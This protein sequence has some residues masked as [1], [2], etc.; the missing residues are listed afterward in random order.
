[1]VQLSV[2]DFRAAHKLLL[3]ARRPDL[4]TALAECCDESGIALTLPGT[5][6]CGSADWLSARVR[7]RSPRADPMA[8]GGHRAGMPRR[9]D[10]DR[11]HL[12]AMYMAHAAH[13]DELGLISGSVF[14]RQRAQSLLA[15]PAL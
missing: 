5:P 13:L 3:D 10:A 11:S 15:S 12:S 6:V 8:R 14:Y 9:P 1:M 2:G 4:A 7:V